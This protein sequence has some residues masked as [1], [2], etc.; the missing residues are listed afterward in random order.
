MVVSEAGFVDVCGVAV[1]AKDQGAS[2]NAV[3]G[4]FNGDLRAW[5]ATSITDARCLLSPWYR[6][7]APGVCR[8]RLLVGGGSVIHIAVRRGGLR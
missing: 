2:R 1:A 5:S 6:G 4:V 8:I 3:V 7:V